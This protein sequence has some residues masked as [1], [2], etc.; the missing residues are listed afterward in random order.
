[1]DLFTT[2]EEMI[3]TL[4]TWNNMTFGAALVMM[5]TN[6]HNQDIVNLLSLVID[7]QRL[8][9]KP[10][11]GLCS[12]G[13]RKDEFENMGICYVDIFNLLQEREAFWTPCDILY[14]MCKHNLER[15]DYYEKKAKKHKM[16]FEQVTWL[17]CGRALRALPSYIREYQL[18]NE[19]QHAFPAAKFSQDENLDK[20]FH[21]DI[22]MTLN[23]KDYYIWSFLYSPRSIC[24]F[25]DKFNNNRHGVVMDGN[26]LLCPFDRMAHKNA[27]YKG[28]SFYS[29]QYIDEIRVALFQRECE[30]Y[31]NVSTNAISLSFYRRPIV[32]TKHQPI[33]AAAN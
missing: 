15:R 6:E 28:W 4:A 18:K 27:S 5:E 17:M 25:A 10:M 16:S 32:V 3:R 7:K 22:K 9:C 20:K 19:L 33:L 13:L 31:H 29:S 23:D 30:D 12:E 2:K 14:E 24:Q 1:M 11:N 21:C 26:H 8:A